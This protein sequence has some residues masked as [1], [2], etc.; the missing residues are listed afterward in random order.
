MFKSEGTSVNR[1]KWQRDQRR[2]FHPNSGLGGRI[3]LPPMK[4]PDQ[5]R[6]PDHKNL[7]IPWIQYRDTTPSKY[8]ARRISNISIYRHAKV[9]S[10]KV[11]EYPR[12]PDAMP[13]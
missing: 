5:E 3:R 4:D 8:P 11:H 9:T 2:I 1:Q 6:S 12:Y 13:S 7:A 10:P